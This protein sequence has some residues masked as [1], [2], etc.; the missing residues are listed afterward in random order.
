MR[1]VFLY[2]GFYYTSI[3]MDYL[4]FFIA[5]IFVVSLMFV[6]AWIVKKSGLNDGSLMNGKSKRLSVVEMLPLD[7]RRRL[8]LIRRDD[9]E[10]LIILSQSGETLVESGISTQE[11][12]SG[13]GA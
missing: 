4:Q 11:K 10:H 13:E 1:A 3:F 8:V 9:K 6:L 2:R 12:Q 7:P 5:L